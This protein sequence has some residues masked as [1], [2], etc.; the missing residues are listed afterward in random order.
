MPIEIHVLSGA[1]QGEQHFSNAESF[2]VGDAGKSD[3]QFNPSKDPGAR[4]KQALIK[5]NS[6]G[7]SIANHGKGTWLINQSELRTGSSSRLRS[8]DIVRVSESGP[9]FR[10]AIVTGRMKRVP[11][12]RDE[13]TTDRELDN[14]SRAT[15]ESTNK[16]RIP[17]PYAA[18]GVL[19]LLLLVMLLVALRQNPTTVS[20]DPVTPQPPPSLVSTPTSEPALDPR[21][22]TVQIAPNVE[23]VVW[24]GVDAEG[25]RI[26]YFSG[27]AVSPK[28]VVS[29]GR[30][31]AELMAVAD[32]V[33]RFVVFTESP[34]PTF[35]Q[36]DE[37]KLHP[38]YDQDDPDST[39]SL[40]HNLGV[41]Y[42]KQ[43]IPAHYELGHLQD[44]NE[45]VIGM[46]IHAV[47]YDIDHGGD[48]SK[49]KPYDLLNPP[50]LIQALGLVQATKILPGAQ[51]SD[52]PLLVLN[53]NVEIS[54]GCEGGP[55]LDRNGK[56]IAVIVS[57]AGENYAILASVVNELVKQVGP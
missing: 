17:L 56:V 13:S 36:I 42:L 33:D 3:L 35:I 48:G 12:T 28:V 53:V 57:K 31:I 34:Q 24:I 51:E 8:G 18:G 43:P 44:L 16:Y 32:K 55:V 47:G 37:M 2:V 41:I 27:W 39:D 1:R 49:F 30:K 54:V 6:D 9:D 11:T 38:R 22:P 52:L 23:P 15:V 5:F 26:P 46:Q 50:S 14:N 29:S 25:Y 19:S 10:F 45:P 21:L 20:Q 40:L 4:D 7:W